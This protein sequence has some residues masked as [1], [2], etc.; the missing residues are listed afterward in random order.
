MFLN[1]KSALLVGALLIPSVDGASLPEVG[2]DVASSVDRDVNC[3][4]ASAGKA[5][6]RS[7]PQTSCAFSD[8]GTAGS[9]DCEVNSD[10]RARTPVHVE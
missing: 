8:G 2:E 7:L 9:I 1:L 10:L 3:A 5:G 4:L 6:V